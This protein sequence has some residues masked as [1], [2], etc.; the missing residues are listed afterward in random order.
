VLSVADILTKC[1]VSNLVKPGDCDIF[2]P[3]L[4]GVMVIHTA[5]PLAIK[6]IDT[7]WI[8]HDYAKM[9]KNSKHLGRFCLI[10]ANTDSVYITVDIKKEAFHA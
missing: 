7:S 1:V 10:K 5:T 4:W 3:E 2:V 8:P 9:P 6:K